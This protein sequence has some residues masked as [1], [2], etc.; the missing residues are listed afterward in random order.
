MRRVMPDF[1][2]RRMTWGDFLDVCQR[3]RI[4]VEVRPYLFD[5][6]LSRHGRWPRIIINAGLQ[7]AYRIFVGFHALGHWVAHPGPRE[8]YLGSPGWLD[9]TELEAST[10]G[11]L[12]LAP[13]PAGPPYPLL[14]RAHVEDDAMLFWVRYPHR[15]PSGRWLWKEPPVRGML[16]TRRGLPMTKGRPIRLARYREQLELFE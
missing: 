6:L 1:A 3:E 2:R 14:E 8:F 11:Y 13:H 9:I 16:G 10:I 4:R 12:A 15:L 5:E 7:E